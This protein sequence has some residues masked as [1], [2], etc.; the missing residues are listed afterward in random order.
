MKGQENTGIAHYSK[1]G[2][3]RMARTLN[4][5]LSALLPSLGVLGLY[6]IK[7]P[8][9]RLG[10][11]VGFSAVFSLVLALFTKARL[12]EIFAATAA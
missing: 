8:L 4:V 11:I 5:L 10:A 9:S 3:K 12:V 2:F 7:D 1:A 6:L